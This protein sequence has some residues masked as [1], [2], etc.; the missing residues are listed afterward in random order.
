MQIVTLACQLYP[1]NTW[2]FLEVSQDATSKPHGYLLVDLAAA[3][4]E[5][6]RLRA[7]LFM[8]VWLVVYT[9]YYLLA[10]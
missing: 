7:G 2:Y 1:T 3:T 8:P 4:P 9:L 10:L 6:F 5:T